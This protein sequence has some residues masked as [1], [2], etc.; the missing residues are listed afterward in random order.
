M[1]NRVLGWEIHPTAHIGRSLVLA[2]KV[3]MGPGAQIG[4]LNVIRGLDEPADGRGR[5]HLLPELDHRRAVLLRALPGPQA[6]PV[7][8]HGRVRHH[9]HR[10][11]ARRHRPDRVWASRPRSPASAPRS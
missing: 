10:A 7:A 11:R 5:Q 3:T 1:A 4:P 2:G 9:H 8:G 6:R